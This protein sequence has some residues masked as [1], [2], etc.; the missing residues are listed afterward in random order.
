MHVLSAREVLA[1]GEGDHADG[2]GV[3]LRVKGVYASWILRYTSPSGRRREF[4]L[5][6]ADRTSLE[7]AGAALKRARKRAYEAQELLD[8]GKDPVDE[9]K[10]KRV[11]ET[12][13]DAQAQ[14]ER[15][16]ETATLRRYARTY[17]ERHIEPV[18]SEK[19]A[20]QWLRSLEG[21]P[22]EARRERDKDKA[23]LPSSLLDAP[24]VTITRADVLDAMVPICRKTP[25]TGVRIFQRLAVI[26]EA[27]TIDGLRAD[28]PCTRTL[29]A[30]MVK[31]AGI[32]ER[33]QAHHNALAH[34]KVPELVK[35]LR[36]MKGNAAAALEWTILTAARTGETLGA[37]W[38]E[39]D[40][41]ARLWRIPPERMKRRRPHV[42]HLCDRALD[43]LKQQRGRH[44]RWIFPTPQ[45][46]RDRPM[47]NMAMPNIL[48]RL[49]IDATCTVHGFRSSFRD[50]V[51][52][53][54]VAASEVAELCLAHVR[55]NKVERA[56]LRTQLLPERRALLTAWG[57]FIE[58]RPYVRAD[59][60][61][62]TD[63]LVMEF[64]GRAGRAV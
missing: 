54:K 2:G 57:E 48:R 44:D 41:Q 23:R 1:A 30:A 42:V 53:R 8:D 20:R 35:D 10:A 28:N 56:Y 22:T 64:P 46:G 5:G 37:Q 15:K 58:G 13:R 50:W 11:A 60:S 18:L 26:L 27:A 16:A 63:A 19:H 14:A 49:G 6:S 7:A 59:G 43:I 51:A 17:H 55:K 31:R 12:A 62:V 25:E 29:Q 39:I 36:T 33:E 21:E 9:R 45:G 38:C 61:A 34:E 47:S 3:Y 4:G 24:I 32:G 52:E 40:E